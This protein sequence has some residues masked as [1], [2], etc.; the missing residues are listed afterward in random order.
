M[1]IASFLLF[2]ILGFLSMVL[3]NLVES[4]LLPGTMNTL[5]LW[6]I[7]YSLW[8]FLIALGVYHWYRAK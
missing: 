1:S 6:V 3:V 8:L 7:I 4:L 5:T 2:G